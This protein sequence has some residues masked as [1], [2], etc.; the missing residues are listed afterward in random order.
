MVIGSVSNSGL[1][2]YAT[3]LVLFLVGDL[4]LS[5]GRLGLV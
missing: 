5:P 2:G 1:T 4:G 3:L